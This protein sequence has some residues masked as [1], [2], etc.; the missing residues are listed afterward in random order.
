MKNHPYLSSVAST[1]AVVALLVWVGTSLVV[2]RS[3]VEGAAPQ[4]KKRM[5]RR[6]HP[7]EGEPVTIT[8]VKVE[9]N[10]VEFKKEFDA[11]DDWWKSLHLT[12]ENR[13]QKP[14]VY[15]SIGL[16]CPRPEGSTEKVSVFQLLYGGSPELAATAGRPFA[17]GESVELQ[18]DKQDQDALGEF[19]RSTG[20]ADVPEIL[21]RVTQVMFY[22]GTKWPAKPKSQP[23][24][25]ASARAANAKERTRCRLSSAYS[26][27]MIPQRASTRRRATQRLASIATM[28]RTWTRERIIPGIIFWPP[29]RQRVSILK[30]TPR[31][32]AIKIRNQ[33]TGATLE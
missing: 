12:V 11:G 2:W 21:V 29:A 4:T 27:T 5:L 31:R 9:G 3:P 17:P 6:E 20:Y 30:D 16:Q 19:L 25:L 10:E 8:K 7:G 14:I 22:D 28:T 32:V 26:P 18:F 15:V 1:I 23:A 24:Y 33:E 13:S